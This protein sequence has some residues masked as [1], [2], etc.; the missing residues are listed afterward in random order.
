MARFLVVGIFLMMF[1]FAFSLTPA[2]LINSGMNLE[3]VARYIISHS[4]EFQPYVVDVAKVFLGIGVSGAVTGAQA[5]SMWSTVAAVT[6]YGIA[7][8]LGVYDIVKGYQLLSSLVKLNDIKKGIAEVRNIQRF[9]R[10][11]IRMMSNMG[12]FQEYY[13][14][15]TSI[16]DY[17][18]T[19][20]GVYFR[21]Y[22]FY[23][24]NPKYSDGRN[25]YNLTSGVNFSVT[26]YANGNKYLSQSL[27]GAPSNTMVL[28]LD[29]TGVLSKAR[30][31]ALSGSYT[32]PALGQ[33]E[34][35]TPGWG[36]WFWALRIRVLRILFFLKIRK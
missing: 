1:S 5:F 14:M 19:D 20:S 22:R 35:F 17:G 3:E 33:W 10:L 11:G 26:Y 15:I 29:T 4:S 12:S 25:L 2:D 18:G 23:F 28:F 24:T 27:N 9:D 36:I 8:G 32:A 31:I 16:Y 6:A 34:L 21:T 30:Q 7:V 13:V